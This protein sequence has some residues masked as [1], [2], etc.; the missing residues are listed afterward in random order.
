MS[1]AKD[2]IPENA[3]SIVVIGENATYKEGVMYINNHIDFMVGGHGYEITVDGYMSHDFVQRYNTNE[4]MIPDA[5]HEYCDVIHEFMADSPYGMDVFYNWRRFF[6]VDSTTD[7][8]RSFIMLDKYAFPFKIP[9]LRVRSI[10]SINLIAEYLGEDRNDWKEFVEYIYKGTP[11]CD[12]MYAVEVQKGNSEINRISD[13]DRELLFIPDGK[14]YDNATFDP[15]PIDNKL[16]Y[17]NHVDIKS[18][19]V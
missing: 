2:Q 17:V 8:Y 6:L 19:M 3:G 4:C 9:E 11:F 12:R 16:M 7:Q 13:Y 5:L 15:S 14:V 18:I 10:E 1:D